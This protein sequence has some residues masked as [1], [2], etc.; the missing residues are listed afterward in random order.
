M[1]MMYCVILDFLT[2]PS[3]HCKTESIL[4]HEHVIKEHHW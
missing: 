1:D 3:F 4:L 2:C